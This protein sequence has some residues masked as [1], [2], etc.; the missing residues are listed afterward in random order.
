MNDKE[1]VEAIGFGLAGVAVAILLAGF[2]I[3]R[4]LRGLRELQ[5]NDAFPQSLHRDCQ[6]VQSSDCTNWQCFSN[7][8]KRI[9]DQ[10]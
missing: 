7:T 1:S 9:Y 3:A 6:F 2:C 4:E 8:S 5:T 10:K